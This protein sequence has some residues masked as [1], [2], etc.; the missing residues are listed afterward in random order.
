MSHAQVGLIGL[1][2]MGE[3]LALNIADK[4]FPIAVFNRTVS[5]VDQFLARHP[6][7]SLVGCHSIPELVQAVER[8]RRIILLVKAGPPVD[9]QMALLRPHLEPG[10]I[11]VD[12]GNSYFQDTERRTKEYA[13]AGLHD[14]FAE[15]NRGELQSYLIEITAEIFT[16]REPDTGQPLVDMILDTAGQKGTGK[17]TSQNALD[18]G[19]P[20]PTI[21]AAV[22]ARI[23]SALKAERVAASR[24]LQGPAGTPPV[25]RK[26]LV[27]QVRQA[28]YAAKVCS[29]A[30][31]MSLLRLAS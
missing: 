3:N 27:Q 9:E 31:G 21:N 8:P 11:C 17:W 4:G 29:Y 1:A 24:V 23:L 19:A 28:L 12:A 26:Q 5:K 13:G 10:D 14:G 30:Q 20:I 22:E 16:R 7:G 6:Q 2:V 25:D 18:L 15:W